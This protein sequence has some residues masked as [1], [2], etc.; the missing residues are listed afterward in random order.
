MKKKETAFFLLLLSIFIL[1]FGR[2]IGSEIICWIA[3]ALALVAIFV[4]C[5]SDDKKNK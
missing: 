3:P 2:S 4:A 1:E 5:W